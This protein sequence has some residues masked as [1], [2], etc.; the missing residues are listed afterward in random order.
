MLSQGF[1]CSDKCLFFIQMAAAGAAAQD[2]WVVTAGE[3]V[4]HEEQFKTLSAGSGMVSGDAAKKFF[5]QSRLPPQ[6]LGVIWYVELLVVRL[7]FFIL[8]YHEL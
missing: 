1:L 2:P 6:V 5:L 7:S 3:K 8:M 4:K